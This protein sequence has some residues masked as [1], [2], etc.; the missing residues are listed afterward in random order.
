MNTIPKFCF[1]RNLTHTI[2]SL[3]DRHKQKHGKCKCP[4]LFFCETLI[5][6]SP[7]TQDQLIGM[8]C[9][10]WAY[11]PIVKWGQQKAPSLLPIGSGSDRHTPSSPTRWSYWL[12]V[13]HLELSSP[14]LSSHSKPHL[15]RRL[16]S[17]SFSYR[18][19]VLTGPGTMTSPTS[20]FL[21]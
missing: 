14:P 17:S 8:R 9:C 3:K 5:F 20:A 12:P 4:F 2:P 10:F 1:R 13:S 15:S 7:K 16:S 6:I 19:P 18:K 11:I 21:S